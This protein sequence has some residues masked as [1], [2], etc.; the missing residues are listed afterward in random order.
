MVIF[1]RVLI[2]DMLK[3]PA[4]VER[5]QTSNPPENACEIVLEA[6]IQTGDLLVTK[7]QWGAFYATEL[8]QQLRRKGIKTIVLGGIAT[9]FGVESTAR[10]AFDQGYEIVFVSDAMAGPNAEMHYFSVQKLFP[11]MGRVRTTQEILDSLKEAH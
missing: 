2:T 11:I 4:D 8:D 1:V 7:R 6:G 10:A 3:L 9:N 5:P